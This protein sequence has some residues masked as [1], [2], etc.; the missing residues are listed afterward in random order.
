VAVSELARGFDVTQPAIS[1]HLASLRRAGLVAERRAGRN[2]YYRARPAGLKPLVD[3]I[4]R[5]QAFWR[6]RL[7]RLDKLLEEIE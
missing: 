5:Y 2:A 4:D 7:T 3:W 6:E 1:Q